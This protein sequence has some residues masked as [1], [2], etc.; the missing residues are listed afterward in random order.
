MSTASPVPAPV[1]GGSPA[2]PSALDRRFLKRLP[3]FAPIAVQLLAVM[4][5]ERK[6]FE[7]I[8]RL[9]ALDPGMAAEVL[10]LANSGLYGRRF[11]VCSIMQ[12][13]ALLGIG[14]ISQM[15]VTAAL[16]RGLPRRTAPFVAGWWRHSIASALIA[17]QWNKDLPGDHAYTAALLH[18]V[19]QLALFEDSRR[20][21]RRWFNRCTARAPTSWSASARY[22]A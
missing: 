20:S 13:I 17:Q 2:Q 9:I 5:D 16:W 12:A 4:A 3:P 6:S 19:G 21:I 18:G 1:P 7:E 8:A 10:R 11:E 22:S 15:V 14:R